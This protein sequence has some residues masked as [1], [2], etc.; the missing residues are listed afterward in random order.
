MVR[1]LQKK[2]NMF[3]PNNRDQLFKGN[4]VI[5]PTIKMFHGDIL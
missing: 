5:F 1:V 3:P 2:L 4:V